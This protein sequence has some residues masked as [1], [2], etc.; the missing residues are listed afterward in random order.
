MVSTKQ[1]FRSSGYV[2]KSIITSFLGSYA[3]FFILPFSF[4]F[5]NIENIEL[6]T[7]DLSSYIIYFLYGYTFFLVLSFG[8]NKLIRFDLSVTYAML[9][10]YLFIASWIVPNNTGILDGVRDSE[11][12]T[13][14]I[15]TLYQFAKLIILNIAIIF[16][17]YRNRKLFKEIVVFCF[18]ISFLLVSYTAIGFQYEAK[19]KTEANIKTET[20]KLA[21][22]SLRKN[23]IVISF[24]AIQGGII[25]D[26]VHQNPLI[27]DEFDGF[28]LYPNT[29]SAAPNTFRSTFLTLTG[30]IPPLKS[31]TKD[32][33]IENQGKLLPV[34]LM[35]EGDYRVSTYGP[36]NM[37]GGV[38]C[39]DTLIPNNCFTYDA[40]FNQYVSKHS[41]GSRKM[42]DSMFYS[43]LRVFPPYLV[44]LV[45]DLL[46]KLLLSNTDLAM[47][48]QD[49]GKLGMGRPYYEYLQF[50]GNLN[51]K[52]ISPVFTF[53]HFVFTHE[54]VTFNSSCS[55]TYSV[56]TEQN[57]ESA[58]EQILCVISLME[59]TI[60]KLKKVGVYDNSL[61][62]F[63]SDH[64][65]SARF[66]PDSQINFGG[67]M[68]AARYNAFLM[69]K[70]FSAAGK[71][72]ISLLPSSLLDVAPTVCNSAINSEYCNSQGYQGINLKTLNENTHRDRKIII[73]RGGKEVLN[74]DFS[75]Y[76]NDLSLIKVSAFDG[77]IKA[78]LENHFK[79]THPNYTKNY[80]DELLL[81]G[82]FRSG[83]SHWT[84]RGTV[85]ADVHGVTVNIDNHLFQDVTV[86]N[87]DQTY[88]TS[89]HIICASDATM[90]AQVNWF[91]AAG[92]FLSATGETYDCYG[93]N[94]SINKIVKPP[95]GA[96]LGRF[97]ITANDDRDITVKS[98]S[99]RR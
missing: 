46:A 28:T 14:G 34:I 5:F 71:A 67:F 11:V 58:K 91:D 18:V 92:A 69:V 63:M 61:I 60:I 76:F 95:S 10:I 62:I 30:F 82:D 42:H 15:D 90:R 88:L 39:R 16:I 87:E 33:V 1:M 83:L 36:D 13:L 44:N 93:N 80:S 53:Q 40:Y 68:P 73:Y 75:R 81:N 99:F 65:M 19:V 94:L 51:A 41:S 12:Y 47:A 7:K 54:P 66:N 84:T 35:N 57:I 29:A 43:A 38:S 72:K 45:N 50:I 26:I 25:G 56:N 89:Y 49:K 22:L 98:V 31:T 79:N 9:F 85:D 24:D 74:K 21:D 70:D 4:I 27:L 32:W 3:I 64:G 97:Y 6:N 96:T 55:Y 86:N 78:G 77:D 2:S 20:I 8:V 17:Y 48:T 52:D 23:I 59:K 37:I